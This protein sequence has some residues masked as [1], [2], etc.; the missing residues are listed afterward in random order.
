LIHSMIDSPPQ[1]PAVNGGPTPLRGKPRG[2]GLRPVARRGGP[3][4]RLRRS[5]MSTKRQRV[6]PRDHGG[7]DGVTRRER[8]AYTAAREA[9]WNGAGRRWKA[10]HATPPARGRCV[11]RQRGSRKLVTGLPLNCCGKRLLLSQHC[12]SAQARCA[13]PIRQPRPVP[14]KDLRNK[15]N[16]WVAPG[17]CIATLQSPGPGAKGQRPIAPG[18]AR[19]TCEAISPARHPHN[20]TTEN[21]RKT[22][23]NHI[24]SGSTGRLGAGRIQVYRAWGRRRRRRVVWGPEDRGDDDDRH[25]SVRPCRGGSVGADVSLSSPQSAERSLPTARRAFF[26]PSTGPTP[27]E[28]TPGLAVG[29]L[30]AVAGV[31]PAAA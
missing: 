19:R 12:R 24:D 9:P 11:R 14:D 31:G 17:L 27:P 16:L 18:Y 5:L 21:S 15:R 7:G 30:A 29:R 28:P 1:R 8:R 2:T 6:H 25:A 22:Y 13:R 20:V 3:G 4:G 10:E 26:P 23:G